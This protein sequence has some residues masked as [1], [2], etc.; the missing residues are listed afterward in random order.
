MPLPLS[1]ARRVFAGFAIYSFAMGNIFPRLA[2]VQ[3]GMG[4]TTSALGLGL[5]GGTAAGLGCGGAAAGFQGAPYP[6]F[7]Q[8]LA[9]FGNGIEAPRLFAAIGM[10]GDD[11]AALFAGDLT[12]MYLH[13]AQSKKLD[14]KEIASS[15]TERNRFM[16]AIRLR[17]G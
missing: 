10:I 5:I 7:G 16:G 8:G 9:R 2:D 6:G 12:R 13:F 1:P 15:P 11:E 3:T 14:V 4:V 17:R